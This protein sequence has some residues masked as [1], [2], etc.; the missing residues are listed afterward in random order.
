VQRFSREQLSQWLANG[1]TGEVVYLVG[2]GGCGMSGLAHLLL[3]FGCQVF[4]SDLQINAEIHQLR[5]RG[6]IIYEGHAPERLRVAE[7]SL[8][9]Y[10]SAVRR[11]NPELA[12]A[13]QLEIPVVRRAALLAILVQQRRGVCIAGMH[14]KTSTTALL[15]HALQ[16]LGAD[17]GH[18]VGAMVPQLARHARMGQEGALMV[19]EAD[20]SDG[21][22]REFF[23]EQAI[24]LN[25]D[26]EHLDYYANF[27][28][29]CDEFTAFAGQTSGSILYCADDPRLVELFAARNDTATFGFNPAAEYRAELQSGGPFRVF[30]REKF[31]GE[32]RI[33]Q[34]GEKNISNAVAVIAFLHR[35]GFAAGAIARA[36]ETFAGA[37]RRQQ[38]LFADDAIRIF[39][40]YGHHPRE[41]RATLAALRENFSGR[42]LVAFQPHRYT[43]TQHLLN[44]FAESFGG[45]DLLWITEVYAA[46]EKPIA[47]VNGRAL[48]AAVASTGQP[49]AYAATLE[50]LREKVRLA[51]RPGDVVLFLGAGD[52][53]RVAHQLAADL[54]MKR[55]SHTQALTELLSDESEVH[56]NEPLAPRTT[57]RVGGAADWF[58]QPATEADL[59]AVVRYA[60]QQALPIFLLG[61]GANLL[62]RDGGIRGIVISLRQELLSEIKVSGNEL[63]C[64]AG[65]G[66]KQ[67]ANAARDHGLAGLEF[68]EGIPGCL[69]GALRMNAGAMGACTFDV[70]QRVRFMAYD[71]SI[72]ERPAAEMGAVYRSCPLLKEHIALGAVLAGQP[73]EIDEVRA[74][75]EEFRRHRTSTQPNA[76]SAGCMFKNPQNIPAGKLVDECGLKGLAVGGASVSERHG[77]FIINEGEATAA[78]VVALIEQVRARVAE[79]RGIDLQTEVQIIGE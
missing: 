49:A 59:G 45:A 38:L 20:E 24:V 71:G 54:K 12:L 69:G 4:G 51:M 72:E 64:G 16:E 67:I 55:T 29:V 17:S 63:H 50:L 62:I 23:P 61:R 44:E 22:L 6:A 31:L 1:A 73:S 34:F 21:T 78:D 53:T 65:A 60:S 56:E 33:R 35:N 36:L 46:S 68:L 74:R 39:D 2:I 18:A 52:I 47:E 11:D 42:L 14:G 77:N 26:E 30:H 8:V 10:S 66:L 13:E 5:E 28:A 19:V 70:A 43:R 41:I 25:I 40:D 75:M 79:Q 15:A 48:A 7:P 3:D 58:V 37:N 27:A 32:F 76:S 57:L 9:A